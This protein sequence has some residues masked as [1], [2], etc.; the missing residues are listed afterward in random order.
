MQEEAKEVRKEVHD[1]PAAK[2]AKTEAGVQSIEN[3][4]PGTATAGP[5]AAGD[6][7]TGDQAMEVKATLSKLT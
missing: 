4:K 6:S 3:G 5:K 2:R 1:E 7:F